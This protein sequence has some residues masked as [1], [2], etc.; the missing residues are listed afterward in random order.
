[1]GTNNAVTGDPYQTGQ[2]AIFKIGSQEF[3][4]TNVSYSKDVNTNDVQ[5]NDSLW[6]R[7][8]ITGLRASG[9]F[10]HEGHNEALRDAIEHSTDGGDH[11]VGEPKR[12]T[13]TIIEEG[14][15][16]SGGNA[17]TTTFEGVLVESRSKDMPADDSVSVTYDWVGESMSVS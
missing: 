8:A 9:S 3:G 14:S 10:E 12:G 2:H 5:M 15:K 13:L 11:E 16:E 7:Q 6:P 17:R 1:M 4:V